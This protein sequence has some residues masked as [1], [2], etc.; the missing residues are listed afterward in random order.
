MRRG[1]PFDEGFV[2]RRCHAQIEHLAETAGVVRHECP[3]IQP[4]SGKDARP[5]KTVI[6]RG[7][8]DQMTIFQ[9]MPEHLIGFQ[10]RT[11]Y[12]STPARS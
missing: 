2:F 3:R 11:T 9:D 12:S 8:H 4:E 1:Q 5:V 7:L 6:V 10:A